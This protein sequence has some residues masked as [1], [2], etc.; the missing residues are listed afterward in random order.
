MKISIET[1][2]HESR[3]GPTE[4]LLIYNPEW[5]PFRE[6]ILEPDFFENSANII[7]LQISFSRLLTCFSNVIEQ[8][9]EGLDKY[10]FETLDGL[11][12]KLNNMVLFLLSRLEPIK[13]S[14]EAKALNDSHQMTVMYI[15]HYER[16]LEQVKLIF[17]NHICEGP[18]RRYLTNIYEKN[19]QNE[20]RNRVIKGP[21]KEIVDRFQTMKIAYTTREFWEDLSM[22]LYRFSQ[23]FFSQTVENNFVKTYAEA[24]TNVKVCMDNINLE[25]REFNTR[26]MVIGFI[27]DFVMPPKLIDMQRGINK[28]DLLEFLLS[29]PTAN[30]RMPQ[31]LQAYI[32]DDNYD[33]ENHIDLKYLEARK[34]IEEVYMANKFRE[35]FR[36]EPIN[37][38]TRVTFLESQEEYYLNI[39]VYFKTEIGEAIINK[40][41]KFEYIPF[42]KI[43]NEK[44][45]NV[46]VPEDEALKTELDREF[47]YFVQNPQELAW[48]QIYTKFFE[49]L[50]LEQF[51]N[52]LIRNRNIIHQGRYY[53]YVDQIALTQEEGAAITNE[54]TSQVSSI[55]D[56]MKKGFGYSKYTLSSKRPL[57]FPIPFSSGEVTSETVISCYLLSSKHMVNIAK[58]ANQGIPFSDSFFILAATDIMEQS[59]GVE[60]KWSIALHWIK[61]TMLKPIL[62]SQVP[63]EAKKEVMK[64]SQIAEEVIRSNKPETEVESPNIVQ[65]DIEMANPRTNPVFIKKVEELNLKA[66]IHEEEELMAKDNAQIFKENFQFEKAKQAAISVGSQGAKIRGLGQGTESWDIIPSRLKKAEVVEPQEALGNSFDGFEFV[67]KVDELDESEKKKA[68][69]VLIFM[70]LLLVHKLFFGTV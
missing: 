49:K 60:V 23:T 2:Y 44:N 58:T 22:R 69:A 40:K 57:P 1:R 46:H 26:Q 21:F 24:L 41:P 18:I 63:P 7:K 35:L 13:L 11:L 70:G 48:T 37:K 10:F 12:N 25:V 55:E 51:I 53:D 64:W 28:H 33:Y 4:E 34:Q 59:N 52:L 68:Y 6:A 31:Y 47:K 9:E 67:E 54:R 16:I 20:F 8:K 45:P 3:T 61:S 65:V 14:Q 50:N 56:N 36:I 15:E 43:K 66:A 29:Q 38:F 39:P 5:P 27:K 30:V 62:E 19:D 42:P 32:D 17:H